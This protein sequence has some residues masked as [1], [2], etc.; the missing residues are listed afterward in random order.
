MIFLNFNEFWRHGKHGMT[1][2]SYDLVED[3]WNQYA[4]SYYKNI[5]DKD[6]IKKDCLLLM[7]QISLI[8]QISENY[9]SHLFDQYEKKER[10]FIFDYISKK[11]NNKD[12]E[13]SFFQEII[14]DATSKELLKLN[15]IQEIKID[16]NSLSKTYYPSIYHFLTKDDDKYDSFSIK[17]SWYKKCQSLKIRPTKENLIKELRKEKVHLF[18]IMQKND[19]LLKKCNKIIKLTDIGERELFILK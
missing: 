18:L 13:E 16:I 10:F 3:F 6:E 11:I 15:K 1:S 9:Y 5:L 14:K 4:Y 8:R 2:S 19:E 17:R 12:K 7:N